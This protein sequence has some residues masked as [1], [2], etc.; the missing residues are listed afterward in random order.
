MTVGRLAHETSF[1]ALCGSSPVPASSG[2]TNRHW[3]NRGGDR[4]AN[5]ALWTTVLVRMGTYGPTKAYY[6][7]RRT[8]EGL[9]KPEIMRCLKRYVA[10]VLFPLIQSIAAG[11]ALEQGGARPPEIA[12]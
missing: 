3:L 9:S 6:V 2:R 1:A 5:S 12:A 7:E 11:S 4:N 8:A 10:R